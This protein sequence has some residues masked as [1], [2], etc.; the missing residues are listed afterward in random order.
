MSSSEKY[1]PY[2]AYS[3]GYD[4]HRGH[5]AND[6]N[7]KPKIILRNVTNELKPKNSK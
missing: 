3:I 4:W 7:V 6:P 5:E 1:K 2:K